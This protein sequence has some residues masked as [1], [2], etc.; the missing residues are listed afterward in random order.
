MTLAAA[1]DPNQECCMMAGYFRK[2]Y[3]EKIAEAARQGDGKQL[4]SETAY[5][6]SVGE[7]NDLITFVC[8]F[9]DGLNDGKYGCHRTYTHAQWINNK[10]VCPRC[11][12][13]NSPIESAMMLTI[14]DPFSGGTF[15]VRC[16]WPEIPYYNTIM[17]I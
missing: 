16:E 3:L 17:H 6:R 1:L 14:K 12:H 11:E 2:V 5:L 15:A 7:A 8:T 13:Q 9:S 10:W 4:D